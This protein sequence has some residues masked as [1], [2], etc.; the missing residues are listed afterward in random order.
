MLLISSTVFSQDS[1]NYC[2]GDFDS[3]LKKAK[4]T[5]KNIFFITRSESCSY[6]FRFKENISKDSK[7]IKFLNDE[8]IVFE[9]DMVRASKEETKRLKKYYHSWRGF[10]QIYFI[11]TN[12]KLISDIGYSIEFDKSHQENLN[13]WKNYQTIE[14]DWKTIK[15]QKR[16]NLTLENL[17]TFLLYREI[18]YS[19]FSFFQTINTIK[20]YF[21][22]IDKKKYS[23]TQHWS[24]FEDYMT[25]RD[26]PELFDYVAQN[27]KDFQD[28]NGVEKVSKYLT[29]NYT[30]IISWKSTEDRKTLAEEYPFNTITEAKEALK[31]HKVIEP[32]FKLTINE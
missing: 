7:T 8:F 2:D 4:Q 30:Q 6:F 19:A 15:Q 28:K 20:K 9:F 3:A 23:D 5:N 17:K 18:K 11:D 1:I 24:L 12:E 26:Y 27:K 10:P 29:K 25:H 14:S 21:K 13:V 22:S 31:N 16:N 32:S